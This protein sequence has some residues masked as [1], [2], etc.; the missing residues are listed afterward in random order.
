MGSL[1]VVF[2]SIEAVGTGLSSLRS[3]HACH[4]QEQQQ[5]QYGHIRCGILRF[6]HCIGYLR[7]GRDS[8]VIDLI[9]ISCSI[10]WS[11]TGKLTLV[12]GTDKLTDGFLRDVISRELLT[13]IVTR[14][15]VDRHVQLV[16]DITPQST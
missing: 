10:A 7:N 4:R 5:Q 12:E 6:L 11:I 16:T 1:L 15:L 2:S 3:C 13:D 14:Q 9:H 8:S